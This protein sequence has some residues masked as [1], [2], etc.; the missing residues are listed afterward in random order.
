MKPINKLINTIFGIICTIGLVYFLYERNKIE[1]RINSNPEFS[2]GKI[3]YFRPSRSGNPVG[4]TNSSGDNGSVEYF[5]VQNEDTIINRYGNNFGKIP[6]SADCLGKK[7]M[8]VFNSN[9]PKESRILVDKPINDS[10]DFHNYI[11]EF[12]GRKVID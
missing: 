7:Y 8:V 6:E 12:E 11:K 9:N 1:N 2:I 4:I 10:V 3:T 5:F